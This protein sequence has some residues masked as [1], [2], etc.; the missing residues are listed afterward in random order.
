MPRPQPQRPPKD[1]QIKDAIV[2]QLRWDG[3]IDDSRLRVSV[4]RG[5]VTLSGTTQSYSARRA[6]LLNAWSVL[7]VTDVVDGMK[8][9]RT[10]RRGID[11][12]LQASV[13]GALVWNAE[14]DSSDLQVAVTNGSVTLTGSVDAY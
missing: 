3:R 12:D 6:A 5:R 9:R 13:T 8:V 1:T 10:S 2:A 11:K 4:R 14:V 7:G